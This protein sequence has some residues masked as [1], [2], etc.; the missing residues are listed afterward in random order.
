MTNL[1]IITST[2]RPGRSGVA[3]E[4]W[5]TEYAASKPAFS[6]EIGFIRNK[7]TFYG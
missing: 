3:V 1:K 5:F 2:T 6:V 4:K 7:F